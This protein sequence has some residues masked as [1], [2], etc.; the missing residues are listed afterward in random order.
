[1]LLLL[2]ILVYFNTDKF[3]DFLLA[4]VFQHCGNADVHADIPI[5][6]PPLGGHT[7][8]IVNHYQPVINV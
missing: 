8:G 2:V 7:G 5:S 6:I 3:A 1:M 4:T